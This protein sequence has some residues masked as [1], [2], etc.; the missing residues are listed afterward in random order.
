MRLPQQLAQPLRVAL[1][2][3][4][5][6]A[7]QVAGVQDAEDG[8]AAPLENRVT[9]LAGRLDLGEQV[10]HRQVGRKEL[11]VRSRPRLCKNAA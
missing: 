6:D 4:E 5:I 2:L 7:E 3:S 8:V 11:D 9:R 10:G 1:K